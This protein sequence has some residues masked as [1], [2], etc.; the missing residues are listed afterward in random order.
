[1]TIGKDVSMLFTDV[2][3]C[4]QTANVELKKLV[5]LYIINYAKSNPDLALLAVNTFCKD[6]HD[7][8]PLIRALAVRTMGESRRQSSSQRVCPPGPFSFSAF[9]C[10]SGRLRLLSDG[11]SGCIRVDRITEYLCDPLSRALRD[12]DPYVRKT[13]AVCVAKLYDIRYDVGASIA[14]LPPSPH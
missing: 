14:H 7:A 3:N 9:R 10:T 5:Y 2:V 11:A 12:D 4:I 13:A 1:M 6:A 8:N